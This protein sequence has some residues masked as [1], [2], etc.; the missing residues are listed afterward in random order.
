M[1]LPHPEFPL[2]VGADRSFDQEAAIRGHR[3]L[4]DR[5][6]AD[7]STRPNHRPTTALADLVELTLRPVTH[8]EAVRVATEA[9]R[10]NRSLVAIGNNVGSWAGTG[11]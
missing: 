7:S 2:R 1:Q 9:H 10:P 6:P 5:L 3:R 11:Q 4:R 8:R